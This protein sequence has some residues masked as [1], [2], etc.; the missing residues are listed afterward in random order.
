ME[1]SASDRQDDQDNADG[2]PHPRCGEPHDQK[3]RRQVCE[4][5][6]EIEKLEI[7]AR[8]V[9]LFA[10]LLVIPRHAVLGNIRPRMHARHA[11]YQG[12]QQKKDKAQSSFRCA[13]KWLL[14]P[15]LTIRR[16]TSL[17]RLTHRFQTCND[18]NCSTKTQIRFRAEPSK[19]S[20]LRLEC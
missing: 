6:P 11:H 9:Y 10:L 18:E 2:P 13:G 1:P 7:E 8:S 12:K 20:W 17:Q 5:R 3:P 15:A 19:T 14:F 4:I 16:P